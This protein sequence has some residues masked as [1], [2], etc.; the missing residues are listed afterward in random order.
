MRQQREFRRGFQMHF[1][2]MGAIAVVCVVALL[3][4]FVI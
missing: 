2:L 3:V 1:V 4:A